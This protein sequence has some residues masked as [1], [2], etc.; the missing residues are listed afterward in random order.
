[1]ARARARAR[2]GGR[3]G[4]ETSESS[5]FSECAGTHSNRFVAS[6]RVRRRTGLTLKDDTFLS[7]ARAPPGPSRASWDRSPPESREGGIGGG[8]STRESARER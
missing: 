8:G 5:G 6:F 4:G 3:A 2:A 7:A 1:V